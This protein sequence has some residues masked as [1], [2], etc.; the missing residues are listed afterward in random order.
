MQRS[1]PAA[2]RPGVRRRTCTCSTGRCIDPDGRMVGKVDDLE[3]ELAEDGTPYVTA[4]LTGPRALGPRLGGRLGRRWWPIAGRLHSAG[5]PLAPA[6]SVRPGH[7]HRQRR[8]RV[9]APRRAAGPRL[10]DWL[11]PA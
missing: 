2:G 5:R 9:G 10:E 3:L 4:L 1:A 7:R 11:G 8:H 6:G